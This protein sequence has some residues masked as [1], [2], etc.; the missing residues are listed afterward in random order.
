MQHVRNSCGSHLNNVFED[1]RSLL[2]SPLN[3]YQTQKFMTLS[4]S[5]NKTKMN[6]SEN[7]LPAQNHIKQVDRDVGHHPR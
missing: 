2:R 7:K 5:T 3:L 6:L 4:F 1:D